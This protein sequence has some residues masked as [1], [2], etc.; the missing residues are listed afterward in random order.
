MDGQFTYHNK[1]GFH[2]LAFQRGTI[3]SVN[4]A[5]VVVK[6]PDG[7][8]WTWLIVGGTVVRQNGAKTTT[9]A[10]AAGQ[11]VFAGGPVVSGSKDARLI[12]IQ[13]GLRWFR[14]TRSQLVWF[15]LVWFQLVWF[16]LGRLGRWAARHLGELAGRCV[17]RRHPGGGDAAAR[18]T[19]PMLLSMLD[20]ET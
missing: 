14:L 4:S 7:T 10:L 15:Q 19:T 8:T 18:C 9:T 5:D 3:Q 20:H 13:A 12:V 16:Q 1:T 17:P 11:A 2:T 6:A